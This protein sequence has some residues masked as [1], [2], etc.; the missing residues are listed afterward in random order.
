MKYEIWLNN[1]LEN[2]VKISSKHRTY[3]NYTEIIKNH[4]V[5]KLGEEEIEELSSYKIQCYITWLLEHGNCK[6]GK[7]LSPSSVNLVIA[8]IQS[9]LEIAYVVGELKEYISLSIK[10]PK[11]VNQEIK[12]LSIENQKKIE[13]VILSMRPLKKQRMIGIILCLY[14]G[15]RIGELLAL[16]WSDINFES[17]ILSINKTCYYGKGKDGKYGRIVDRPKTSTSI[18][19]IPIPKQI[20][21]LLKEQKKKSHAIY[22]ISNGCSPVSIRS[23]QQSFSNLLLK[24]YIPHEGFH[25]LRHTFATRAIEC[26]MD[27]KSL[28]EIL[29]HKNPTI[30]LNRYVHALMEHKREMM[31][32]L[33]KLF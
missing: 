4:I 6:T 24:N 16:E 14:T 12:C 20:I 25:V 28:S 11:N 32:K 1:W 5:P 17:G 21:S 7:G 19:K 22:V 3:I 15:L 8:I 10:R 27:V 18:R 33:G 23:Y 31:N 2:Y 29:G 26:G 13:S 30:T 9:S